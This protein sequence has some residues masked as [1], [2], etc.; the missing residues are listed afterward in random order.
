MTTRRTIAP[1]EIDTLNLADPR[2]RAESD[3][4]AVW[5]HLRERR[6]LH[7]CLSTL[8]LALKAA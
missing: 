7:S 3:L 4:S 1:E 8:P 2:L 5:H 6:P